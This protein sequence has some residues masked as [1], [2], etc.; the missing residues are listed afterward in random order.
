MLAVLREAEFLAEALGDPRRL[1]RVAATLSRE[2][3]QRGAHDQA[4][5]TA[6]RI[7]VLATA[8]GDIVLHA[9]MH[10]RLGVVY[11]AQGNYRRAI[12]YFEQAMALFDGVRRRERITGPLLPAVFSRAYLAMGHAELGTF[13]EGRYLGEAGLQIAE[14]VAHPLSIMFALRGLGVLGLRQGDLAR[15]LPWLE[16]AMGIVQEADFKFYFSQIAPALGMMYTLSGRVADAIPLFTQALEQIRVTEAVVYQAFCSLTMGEAQMLANRLAE[17]HALTAGTLALTRTHQERGHQA[18]ALRLLGDIAARREPPDVEHAA[19]SYQQ[20]LAL[21][22]ELGMRPLQAHC[23]RGLGMLYATTGQAEQ[24]C[25]ELTTAIEM[26]QAMAM[27][28]WLPETEAALAQV[29]G[30]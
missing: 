2:F 11:Q 12:D 22:E 30:R 1:G 15:A 8:S 26:Y 28:F 7:L 5:A 27:T 14:E 29:E 24:S 25:T 21:A 10:N 23:H 17:A 20:A 3:Y 18:Y 19:A 16:R 9:E 6:Q 4:L 13:A